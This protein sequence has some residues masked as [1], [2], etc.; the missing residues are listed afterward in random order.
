M[1]VETL[2]SP[3]TESPHIGCM[4][5]QCPCSA[6]INAL[7]SN[8]FLRPAFT[9]PSLVLI[10]LPKWHKARRSLEGLSEGDGQWKG[11]MSRWSLPIAGWTAADY[12]WTC[13]LSNAVSKKAM[14]VAPTPRRPRYDAR[15]PQRRSRGNQ[16]TTLGIF[17]PPSR[18]IAQS[19][20]PSAAPRQCFGLSSM[21]PTQ[22]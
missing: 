17:L 13:S 2:S 9:P 8:H 15:L 6:G 19:S 1:N 5:P 10:R 20:C 7:P 18:Y 11:W 21:N 3:C 16:E 14:I 22:A 4:S 12:K